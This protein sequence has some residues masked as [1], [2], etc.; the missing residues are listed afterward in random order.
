MLVI[1]NVIAKHITV[2]AYDTLGIGI[3][4]HQLLVAVCGIGIE[5]VNVQLTAGSA[6]SR[7]ESLLTQTSYLAYDIGR[8][9]VIDNVNLVA[10]MIGGAQELVLG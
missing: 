1:Y 3:P 10:A 6:A 5:L 9:V 2:S 8:V 7:T 4:Q